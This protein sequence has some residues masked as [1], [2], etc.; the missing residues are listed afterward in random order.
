MDIHII[1]RGK[2]KFGQQTA[3]V[4]LQTKDKKGRRTSETKHLIIAGNKQ[5]TDRAGN[6]YTL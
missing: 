1:S 2:N 6:H 4:V 5:Y 3:Q